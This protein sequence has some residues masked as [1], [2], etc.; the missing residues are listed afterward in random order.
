MIL[1]KIQMSTLKVD[2]SELVFRFHSITL[3]HMYIFV[4]HVR[5]FT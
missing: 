2:K 3:L 5:D 4:H 1:M